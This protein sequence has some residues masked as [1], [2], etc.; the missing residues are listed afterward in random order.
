MVYNCRKTGHM[1]E[2]LAKLQVPQTSYCFHMFVVFVAAA[3]AVVVDVDV[4]ASLGLCWCC[5]RSLLLPHDQHAHSMVKSS[6]VVSL[7]S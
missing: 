5:G 3:A 2:V 7:C 4:F 6:L 1:C